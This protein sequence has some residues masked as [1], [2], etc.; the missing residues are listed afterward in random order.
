MYGVQCTKRVWLNKN[1]PKERDIQTAFQTRIFQQGT[2]IGLLARQL[3]PGGINAEPENFYSYQQSVA[4]T[5]RYIRSGHQ[6]IYEAAFQF[7]GILCAVDLLVKVNSKWY[8]FEVKSTNGVKNAHIY[9]AALQYYVITKAGIELEDFSIIHLNKTYI[10]QGALNIQHL[11]QTVSVLKEVLE[12]NPFISS[13]SEE[14]INVLSKNIPPEI[15]IGDHCNIPYSCDFQQFCTKGILPSVNPV[16]NAFDKDQ[17]VFFKGKL[18]FPVSYL[19]MQTWSSAIPLF[20]G[21]HPYKQVCFQFSLYKQQYA[22]APLEH[23]S[24][25]EERMNFQQKELIE[26]LI[27]AAG[28]KGSIV[29]HKGSYLKF[30]LQ[31]FKKTF[32]YLDKEINSLQ[33]RIVELSDPFRVDFKIEKVLND[34]NV[35]LDDLG[36]GQFQEKSLILDSASASA[37]YFNLWEENDIN[38]IKVIRKALIDYSEK[39]TRDM[40]LIVL[41][42]LK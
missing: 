31:E 7:E 17:L 28:E 20:D 15:E 34:E 18:E 37:A 25:F 13:K 11:F 41:H 29:I 30:H 24:F 4:D 2:N 16:E 38:K 1:L 26:N 33:T 10:R 22:D 6:I 21:H 42:F 9:D 8:A 35:P 3:F 19:S 14:L 39:S 40:A 5:L 32:N 12:L 23:Y 27:E 36:K